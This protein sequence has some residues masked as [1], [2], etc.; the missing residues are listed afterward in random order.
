MI[1]AAFCDLE[2][3]VGI[4]GACQAVGRARASH[5]RR[6]RPA[7]CGP[8]APRPTPP[9]ALSALERQGVLDTLHSTRF[10][11]AAPAHVWATLLDEGAYLASE[12][13]MYRL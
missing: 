8:P 7:R 4:R 3:R 10:A 12:S 5:S 9:N 11:D 6:D 13:T 1:D 2:A